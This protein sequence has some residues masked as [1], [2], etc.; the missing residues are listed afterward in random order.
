[1]EPRTQ[2]KVKLQTL[3]LKINFNQKS[4]SNVNNANQSVQIR[5]RRNRTDN[6]G[7][8]RNNEQQQHDVQNNNDYTNRKQQSA[9][10]VSKPASNTNSN[11]QKSQEKL[12][13]ESSQEISV[14]EITPHNSNVT[15]ARS[16][17][18]NLPS[19]DNPT[20]SKIKQRKVTA[21][22]LH[23]KKGP[24]VVDLDSEM[25]VKR[26]APVQCTSSGEEDAVADN[27]VVDVEYIGKFV[28]V[29]SVDSD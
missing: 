8:N 9:K 13:L 14:D 3:T 18:K 26:E 21:P 15:S 11:N 22:K 17:T 4:T 1:M 2:T 20:T 28:D 6:N 27:G 19:E 10:P 25:F 5:D 29:Q 12:S 24:P 16:V 23:S 7:E